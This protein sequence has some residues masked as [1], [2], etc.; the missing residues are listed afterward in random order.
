M[1]SM[2]KTI[3]LLALVSL[4][5]TLSLAVRAQD[6]TAAPS[7]GAAQQCTDEVKNTQYG[8]FREKYKTEPQVAY[9]AAKAYLAACPNETA[10]DQKKIADYLRNYITKYDKEVRKIQLP[11]LILDKKYA[12]AFAVGKQILT[13]EP[14]NVSVIMNL[15]AAGYLASTQAK[16]ESFNAESA[17]YAK[18]ALELIKSGKAP[19][20]NDWKP[21]K[22]K[23]DA[24]GW[25]NYA[26]GTYTLRTNPTEAANYFY[27]VSQHE[28]DFKKFPPTYYYLAA[29]YETGPYAKLSNDYN[30]MYKDKPE[31]PESKAAQENI[32]QVV[33]RAIDAYARAVAMA[34]SDPKMAAN[35]AEWSKRLTELYTYRNKS[36]AGLPAYIS[37]VLAKPLPNPT[38]TPVTAPTPT[39]ND[40]TTPSSTVPSGTT[41]SG[42]T[43]PSSTT[44]PAQPVK[45]GTT[46][47]PAK[48]ATTQPGVKSSTTTTTTKTPATTSKK[49]TPRKRNH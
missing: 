47:T 45:P 26:M 12:D 10:E 30:A 21:F 32:N 14:D 49:T 15:G 24:L 48:P 16:N 1:R 33:D 38:F 35:K 25:L 40:G 46:T 13:D 7:S 4:L 42:T 44:T 27:E 11:Q 29:A 6:T 3:Q 37:G 9:A 2:K 22:N 19:E 5:A 41:P 8:I 36:E 18:R 34:G 20:G 43:T 28:S 31:T 23:D 39:A 17:P